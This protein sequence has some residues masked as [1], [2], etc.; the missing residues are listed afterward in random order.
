MWT[1]V[2]NEKGIAT[3]RGIE[4]GKYRVQVGS[5]LWVAV[6]DV[7]RGVRDL[8]LPSKSEE[9]RVTRL[10]AAVVTP[11]AGMS[12]SQVV[13]WGYNSGRRLR[14]TGWHRGALALLAERYPE[15]TIRIA[16]AM[17]GGKTGGSVEVTAVLDNGA[18]CAA[19]A[20]LRP[21]NEVVPQQLTVTKIV[22]TR[23][24][25]LVVPGLVDAS[26]AE[27]FALKIG[28]YVVKMRPGRPRKVPCGTY[29]VS[30]ACPGAPGSHLWKPRQ[31]T[32]ISGSGVQ[33]IRLETEPLR[34][35]TLQVVFSERHVNEPVAIS[36][37]NSQGGFSLGQLRAGEATHCVVPY[38]RIAISGNASGYKPVKK[39]ITVDSAKLPPIAFVLE[40]KR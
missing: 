35:L 33:E 27:I 32:V 12:R 37:S 18:H 21:L 39:V 1:A 11:P 36:V 3:V 20:I 30:S 22:D 31:V 28:R 16:G 10:I 6:N 14:R 25:R 40:K 17:V 34:L 13:Y 24:V 26:A 23:Q 2:S 7:H 4:P 15:A 8:Y 19:T 5:D 9:V 38:G 29:E